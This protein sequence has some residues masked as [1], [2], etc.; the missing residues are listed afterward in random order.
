MGKHHKNT[1]LRMR[2]VCEIV[3]QHYEP[4]NYAKSY[5]QVWKK[6]VYP[7]YPM[8]YH[9]LIKYINTPPERR[10]PGEDNTQLKLFG[11]D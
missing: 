4:G 9:T 8:C 11:N 6:Y 1:M 3:Q 10:E 5:R 7:V 2:K